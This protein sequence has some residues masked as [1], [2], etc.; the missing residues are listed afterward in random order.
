LGVVEQVLSDVKRSKAEQAVAEMQDI[1]ASAH[2][3]LKPADKIALVSK[4]FAI[5]LGDGMGCSVI[6]RFNMAYYLLH[7]LATAAR[8]EDELGVVKAFEFVRAVMEVGPD[9]A[10]GTL[11]HWQILNRGK[12]NTSGKLIYMAVMMHMKP[13]LCPPA[14]GGLLNLFRMCCLGERVLE[15]DPSSDRDYVS[16]LFQTAVFRSDENALMSMP[17]PC[18]YNGL[19]K[20]AATVGVHL[21]KATHVG[22]VDACNA[23]TNSGLSK[24]NADRATRRS[25][26][27]QAKSYMVGPPASGLVLWA[28]GDIN[29]LRAFAPPQTKAMGSEQ[30]LAVVNLL[31][32]LLAQNAARAVQRLRDV[33]AAGGNR[34]AA[35]SQK[36][37]T[38]KGSSEAVLWQVQA[39][40]V[41]AAAR[42]RGADGAIMQHSPVVAKMFAGNPVYRLQAF[43][44]KEFDAVVALVRGL[45]DAYLEDP[46]AAMGPVIQKL[47]SAIRVSIAPVMC[48]LLTTHSVVQGIAAGAPRALAGSALLASR[49]EL[50]RPLPLMPVPAVPPGAVAGRRR[51]TRDVMPLK[52]LRL[53][54][55]LGD[56]VDMGAFWFSWTRP[57]NGTPSLQDLEAV[58][59]APWR[60]RL[61]LQDDAL[62]RV[63]KSTMSKIRLIALKVEREAAALSPQGTQQADHAYAQALRIVDA[64]IPPSA[65]KRSKK[66][67]WEGLLKVIRKEEVLRKEAPAA[68]AL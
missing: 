19:L 58:D 38:I 9:P 35:K 3:Q 54:K 27:V 31:E 45:E 65:N 36:L 18:L 4:L 66:R 63:L 39:A 46:C 52:G 17:Y 68:A 2:S 16:P 51:S 33:Q 15:F 24:D 14:A 53:M 60:S 8:S 41:Q 64:L 47:G 34:S 21:D 40:V 43:N 1:Q 67:N 57:V 32:P 50:Q 44:S 61:T 23:A 22:R 62:C 55:R 6:A 28:G 25:N 37:F 56:H 42:P 49:V 12:T 11:A 10:E 30:V 5:N 7:S 29:D 20:A 26:D 59:G 48:Q 13:L